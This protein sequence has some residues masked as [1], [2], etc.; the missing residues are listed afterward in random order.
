MR[1]PHKPEIV[2]IDPRTTETAMAATLHLPL[3][4][5][6]DLVLLYGLANMLIAE[7]LDRPRVHR[8]PHDAASRSSPRTSQ[9]SRPSVVAATTGLERRRSSTTLR[10]PI[11]ER[12]AGL[13][14][15]D[16]GRQPEPRGRPDGAGDHQPGADDRQHRPARHRAPTRSPASATRWA[17]GCSA[18]RPTCSA[19]TTSP[20]PA[21]RAEGRRRCSASTRPASRREPSWAY[22]RDHRGHPRGQDQGPVGHRHE[23]RP[24]VDRPGPTRARLLGK[25]DFLVVQDMYHTTE[26]AP[27]GR[28]RAAGRRLG[29]EGGD[30]HQLRAADRPDQEGRRAPG[31]ALADFHIFKLIAHYWG[32]GDMF[33]EWDIARGRLPDPQAALARAGPATS[34]ASATTACSTSRGGIQWPYPRGRRRPARP[35]G[36]C[37]RTGGSIH[38]DG[39]ARFIFEAPRADARADRR[40]SIPFCCSPAAAARASGTRRRGRRSPRVLRKLYPQQ[41]YVEINPD[42]A[43]R[44]GVSS[45]EECVVVES[46]RGRCA[47][48]PSSRLRR[49]AGAGL[50]PHAR[51]G[52]QP[53]DDRGLRP[54]L[55]AAVVQGLRRPRPQRERRPGLSPLTSFSPAQR[56]EGRD[57]GSVETARGLLRHAPLLGNDYLRV[58]SR[59]P[60]RSRRSAWCW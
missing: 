38:P 50:H 14:L 55:A 17:R 53:A 15:V 13:V 5:K 33:R 3:R 16:D 52:D 59:S 20:T 32:C 48:G 54:L 2:V 9:R 49:A 34:P 12:Q 31:Q 6:S 57:E 28:P 56:G 7:R 24:L 37:S 23:P 29:R 30:V 43:Q 36:G 19:A 39:R 11:H 58:L 47:P 40:A 46:R 4:P 21:H 26:T 41:L 45:R 10:R 1:N 22:D 25:L 42:D 44:P 35:S 27:A 60:W 8:R 51:R 18:T